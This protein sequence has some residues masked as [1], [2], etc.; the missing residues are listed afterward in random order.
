MR[1]FFNRTWRRGTSS[2]KSGSAATDD[3]FASGSMGRSRTG[4]QRVASKTDVALEDIEGD[5]HDDTA[6][7]E[8]QQGIVRTVHVSVD[9]KAHPQGAAGNAKHNVVP[10][11]MADSER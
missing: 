4:H 6:S 1:P 11:A 9:W 10:R 2:N 5:V 3:P 8:S 7:R